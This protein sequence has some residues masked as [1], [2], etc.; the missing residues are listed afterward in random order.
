VQEIM[1]LAGI[2]AMMAF[3]AVLAMAVS[4]FAGGG[5]TWTW[6]DAFTASWADRWP[7]GVQEEGPVRWRVEALSTSRRVDPR[8]SGRRTADGIPDP[9]CGGRPGRTPAAGCL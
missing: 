9:A 5:D 2:A 1:A 4:R 8:P 6:S 7:V 3:V